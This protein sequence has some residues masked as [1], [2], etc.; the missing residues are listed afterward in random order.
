MT[1]NP[2]P[3]VLTDQEIDQV[4]AGCSLF[5]EFVSGRASDQ[6][7][8]GAFGQF[9]AGIS[10]SHDRPNGQYRAAPSDL[11]DMPVAAMC[12]KEDLPPPFDPNH[13]KIELLAVPRASA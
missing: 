10:Y 5:G 2:L 11:I 7:S 4:S 8:P 3:R 9:V 6:P 12:C 13:V 1:D